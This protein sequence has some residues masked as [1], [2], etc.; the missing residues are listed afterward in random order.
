MAVQQQVQS[1]S[2]EAGADLNADQFKVMALSSG[3]LVLQTSSSAASLGVLM[4]NPENQGD[5]AELAYAGIVKIVAGAAV[6]QDAIVMSDT[7]G[8]AIPATGSGNR[9]LGQ[10]TGL[11]AAG[12]GELIEVLLQS[13]Q[14]QLP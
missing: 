11:A 12:A 6:A 2:L 1:V 14:A 13:V 7:V 9:V 8:R 5:A 4:N 10:V 3:Q